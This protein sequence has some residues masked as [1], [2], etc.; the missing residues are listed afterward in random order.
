[1]NPAD[2]DVRLTSTAVG[3]PDRTVADWRRQPT[4][5]AEFFG[6]L[7]QVDHGR[8]EGNVYLLDRQLTEVKV[9]S[10]DG[11]YISHDGPRGRGARRVPPAERSCFITPDGQVA[12]M[13]AAPGKIVL[14]TKG[15][16]ARR[17]V[18]DAGVRGRRLPVLL[19]GGRMK[20][21][22]GRAHDG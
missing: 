1:M 14:L 22:A 2:P 9:F 7:N 19:S 15:R 10:P 6:V 4:N 17:R 11:E 18:P 20:G 21:G 13:Q 8:G 16:R 5:D 12:V 3:H